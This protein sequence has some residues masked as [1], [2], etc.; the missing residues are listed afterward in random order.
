MEADGGGVDL[1][2]EM[3]EMGRVSGG[4]GGGVVNGDED[5]GPWNRRGRR[6][7]P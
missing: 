4:E 1:G 5:L 6:C 7:G 2:R 3:A